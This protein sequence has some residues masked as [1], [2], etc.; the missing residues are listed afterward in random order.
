M[1]RRCA[2]LV[3]LLGLTACLLLPEPA[4]AQFRGFGG[5][6]GSYSYGPAHS[7]GG[8]GGYSYP[9]Y[10][11]GS[12]GAWPANYYGGGYAG[13]SSY[14]G[15]GGALMGPYYANPQPY[16][17]SSPLYYSSGA[18]YSNPQPYAYSSPAYYSSGYGQI[19]PASGYQSY[20]ASYPPTG[21]TAA[22]PDS[23]RTVIHVHVPADA[24]VLFDDTPMRQTG[25]DRHFMTPPLDRSD[26]SYQVTVRWTE[27]G[28]E[29]RETRTV[30]A[31]PGQTVNLDFTSTDNRQPTRAANTEEPPAQPKQKTPPEK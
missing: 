18:Y 27:N 23:K 26:Y 15:Y 17:Y 21:A 25:T 20:Q 29:R 1:T 14:S 6:F 3:L 9:G 19:A 4:F 22:A 11:Y 24:Q 16:N 12:Y 30:R 28:K 5:G 13:M 31:I 7:Y 8:Y 10:A 2:L